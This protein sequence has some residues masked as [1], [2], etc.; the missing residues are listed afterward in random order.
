MPGELR[1]PPA[2]PAGRRRDLAALQH[3]AHRL[4]GCRAVTKN[5][6]THTSN[7]R[8]EARASDQANSKWRDP[9]SNWGHHDFQGRRTEPGKGGKVLQI[10]GSRIGRAAPRYPWFPVVPGGLRTWRARHVLFALHC[11]LDDVAPTTIEGPPSTAWRTRSRSRVHQSSPASHR[12]RAPGPDAT[13]VT[14][15]ERPACAGAG[16]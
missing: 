3:R 9:D 7:S 1:M 16:R 15:R 6:I 5:E 12:G 2:P 11:P 14:V 10:G 4:R 8:H 13:P